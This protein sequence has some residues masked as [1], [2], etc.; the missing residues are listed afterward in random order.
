MNQVPPSPPPLP[1]QNYFR[2]TGCF[3]RFASL[4]KSKVPLNRTVRSPHLTPPP[5]LTESI[6]GSHFVIAH[7]AETL[8]HLLERGG[9][10]DSIFLSNQ[11]LS[12]P[13]CL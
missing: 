9:D 3:P 5:A 4:L 13:P 12:C 7:A 6:D 2:E 8:S 11:V 1:A 10:R